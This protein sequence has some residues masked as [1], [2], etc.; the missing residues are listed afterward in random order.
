M[1]V[2]IKIKE[3]FE[4][5]GELSYQTTGSAAFDL[6]AA[7]NSIITIN[8]G[9]HRLI[10]TGLFIEVPTGYMLHITPRS[11]LAFKNS[12]SI[13]NSPGIIDSDYRG[14]IGVVIINHG[15]FDFTIH[16][17]DRIAQMSIVPV[18]QAEF[19]QVENISETSR[20]EGGFG[21]TGHE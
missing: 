17:G 14:E 20:G 3:G 16:R 5:L 11:G 21:H 12:I 6:R 13:V 15:K 2:N 19:E 9:E 18:V 10:S 4:D 8:P 1:N 7:I